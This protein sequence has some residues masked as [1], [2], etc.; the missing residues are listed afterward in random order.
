M[1]IFDCTLYYDEDLILD[2]RLNILDKYID[3]F[4]ICEATFTHS[5]RKKKLNFNIEKFSKFKDKI[6][7][8]IQD[9]E[10]KDIIYDDISKRIE[11]PINWRANA[12]KRI[13]HQRNKLLEEVN[14]HA[15]MNDFILYSDNDEIPNLDLHDITKENS[16]IIIFEQDLYY[17]KFNLLCDRIKWYGTRAIKKKDLINFEWLREVKPK[18]YPFYRLDTLLKKNKYTNLRILKNGGWHFTRVI[19]PEEIHAKELDAEHHD[20][21]RASNKNP[22]RIRDLINRRMIDHDHLADSKENKYGKEFALKQL[23]L[24]KMP[25]Y[26]KENQDKYKEYLDL[27]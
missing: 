6:I 7:Y 5:G 25:I 1:K 23:S 26:I 3:K 4:I 2:A 15:D 10:P 24:E 22:E 13:S 27:D 18:K 20:E 21:Y 17:F 11:N 16:K 12:V 9:T 8:I 14:K 19:S